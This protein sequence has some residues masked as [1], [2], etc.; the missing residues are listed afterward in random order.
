LRSSL[1]FGVAGFAVL[2]FRA[3]DMNL[4]SLGDESATELGVDVDAL[5]RIIFVA[6]SVMIGAAVS[7]SGIISFVGLIVPHT[8]RLVS[9]PIIGCCCRH[10]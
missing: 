7:V 3:R 2:M 8:L 4:L 5:R 10:R 1:D 9:A 6:T